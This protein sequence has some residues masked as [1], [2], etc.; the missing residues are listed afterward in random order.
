MIGEC[1]QI[2]KKKEIGEYPVGSIYGEEELDAIRRVLESGC[3]LTRG[4]DVELFEKEFAAYLSAKYAISTSSCGTALRIAG[5]LLHLGSKDEVIVQANAFWIT[6]VNLL[7]RNVTIRSADI[8]PYTLNIDPNK[9]D[10]FAYVSGNYVS[11][12][13]GSIGRHGFSLTQTINGK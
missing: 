7:E 5:Q 1:A 10:T 2:I 8:D 12:E 6:L 11:L 9:I 3:S 13:R 4:P